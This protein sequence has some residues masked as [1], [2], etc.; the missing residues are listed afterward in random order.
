V[1]RKRA[2]FQSLLQRFRL[3]SSRSLERG[4]SYQGEEDGGGRREGVGVSE[5]L[6][7]AGR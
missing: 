3:V 1:T 2:V 6:V 5:S 7:T 4:M